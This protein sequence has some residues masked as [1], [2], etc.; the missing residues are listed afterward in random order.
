[1]N[2]SVNSVTHNNGIIVEAPA[3]LHLGFLD[4][5]G[6][7][8]R[9]FSSLGLT[10]DGVSTVLRMAPAARPEVTGPQASR[11]LPLLQKLQDHFDFDCNVSVTLSNAIPEH[12]GL[13]SGTQL[14]LA[15][16]VARSLLAGQPLSARQVAHAL[17]RGNRSGIGV[18]AFEVGGFL[19]DG[20]RGVLDAPPPLISRLEF[21]ADWR[22]V[23]MLDPH[24]QGV[25]GIAETRAFAELPPFPETLA[26]QLCRQTLMQV[27]PALTEGD[28]ATFGRAI[29]DIQ[30]VVGDHFAPAQGG[31]YTSPAVA[32][33][34]TL[35]ESWDVTCVGQSSWGP[36]GFAIVA[37]ESIAHTLIQ[38]LQHTL[39][40][41]TGLTLQVVSA[42]NRGGDVIPT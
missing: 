31:R 27:L 10:L 18:A 37:S 36:T 15:L 2:N 32:H 28:L 9:R 4:M 26:A 23:L 22:I 7:L 33:A 35:L 5:H 14:A 42:R 13:G 16:G 39:P 30:H 20:G 41:D 40:A 12:A 34:L 25:H 19:L 38:K 29:R 3:R 8:Q 6:G 11:V 24:Q 17:D 1:M 21:P